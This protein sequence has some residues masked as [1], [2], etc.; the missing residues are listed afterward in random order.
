MTS[1]KA[2]YAWT[3]EPRFPYERIR[4]F[5][6]DLF[7][8]AGLPEAD[9]EIAADAVLIADM[10]GVETHG[11]QRMDFYLKGLRL[12]NVKPDAQM[13]VVREMPS[14][15]ALDGNGGLGL[16][17]AHRAMK[18]CIEKAEETG[19]CLATM[20]SSSHFGIAGMYALMAAERGMGGMAMTNTSP[21]V[22]PMFARKPALGT[23]PIAFA[24]PTGGKPFC[25]DMSTSTVAVGKIEVAK[26]LGIPIP[27][28]WAVD[29]DGL[30]T[31]DPFGAT[32]LTPL[33]GPREHSGHKGYGLG[34]M[35]EIFCGQL[36]GN[37]WSGVIPR[38]HEGGDSG[39][40]GH[41]FMA[42]RVDAFRDLDDFTAE[43]DAM[44]AR[45]REMDV[46]EDYRGQTVLIPGDPEAEAEEVNARLGVPV[47]R[48]VL[49]EL[50]ELAK[51]LGVRPLTN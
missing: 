33:G 13:T 25:L 34:L 5:I 49:A 4:D 18:R 19:I 46:A 31:T 47:R 27:Q 39:E 23:N 48:A 22:V 21:L 26:R 16:V 17:M 8:S 51:D 10:R 3:D 50:E 12:G 6:R 41:M 9:A 20:R 35:V 24:I 36:A 32:G 40:T 44:V 42:W 29:K 14:T 43:M 38:T 1:T 11:V 15:I 2:A 7:R 30:P 28:G 45:L 37:P